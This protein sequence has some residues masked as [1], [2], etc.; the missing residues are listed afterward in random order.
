MDEKRLTYR[1]LDGRARLTLRGNQVYCSTQATA[2]E[3]CLME[4]HFEPMPVRNVTVGPLRTTGDC[5]GCGLMICKQWS[6]AF[7]G[8]CGQAVRWPC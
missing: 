5:P 7:C 4:E 2:D 3:I 1:E 6:P 8:A